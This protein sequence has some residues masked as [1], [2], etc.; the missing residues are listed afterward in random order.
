MK[1]IF[2]LSWWH[3]DSP[4]KPEY[5]RERV[6]HAAEAFSSLLSATGQLW[7]ELLRSDLPITISQL[8]VGVGC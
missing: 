3:P 8:T 7:L 6:F 2:W 1:A 5:R 4:G